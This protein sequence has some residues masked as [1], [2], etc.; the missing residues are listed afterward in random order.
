MEKQI[1]EQE[2]KLDAAPSK[3]EFE[4]LKTQ[5]SEL[6]ANLVDIKQQ[7]VQYA[8]EK[9]DLLLEIGELKEA[10]MEAA[11]GG[12]QDKIKAAEEVELVKKEV[13]TLQGKIAEMERVAKQK[14]ESFGEL[15]KSLK[16]VECEKER[17]ERELNDELETANQS[18]KRLKATAQES[19]KESASKD[20]E[21][22]KLENEVK[23][24]IQREKQETESREEMMGE[25]NLL[26]QQIKDIQD[27]TKDKSKVEAATLKKKVEELTADLERSRTVAESLK[28][29]DDAVQVLKKELDTKENDRARLGEEVTLLKA[30][31]AAVKHELEV[32]Y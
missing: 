8:K 18:K 21:I 19:A 32:R 24:L 6:E 29:E 3:E 16:K 15:E 5:H 28:K 13:K 2:E 10:K 23:S 17:I 25:V 20:I 26:R 11:G 14:T 30:D 9:S 7:N 4:L 22:S 27:S 1:A 31:V 12:V